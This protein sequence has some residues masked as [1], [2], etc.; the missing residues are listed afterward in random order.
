[1][2]KAIQDKRKKK[3]ALLI[4]IVLSSRGFKI[5]TWDEQGY[6]RVSNTEPTQTRFTNLASNRQIKTGS[7]LK[8]VSEQ[9]KNS[10]KNKLVRMMVTWDGSWSKIKNTIYFKSFDEY[11]IL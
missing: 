3:S 9:H 1:M 2:W 10:F 7:Y 11:E 4:P 6:Q 5:D 8:T